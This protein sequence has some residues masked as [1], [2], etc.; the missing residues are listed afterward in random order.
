MYI[1]YGKTEDECKSNNGPQ[2]PVDR[3][4][5]SALL[6]GITLDQLSQQYTM[7][8]VSAERTKVG[9]SM[10]L[11]KYYGYTW[12]YSVESFAARM[13]DSTEENLPELLCAMMELSKLA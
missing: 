3:E 2:L 8:F 9:E 6:Q 1:Q 5:A 12:T 4:N 10:R 13:L 11:M 7:R